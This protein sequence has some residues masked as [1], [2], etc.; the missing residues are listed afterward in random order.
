MQKY[1][2][3]FQNVLAYPTWT[4]IGQ[5]EAEDLLVAVFEAEDLQLLDDDGGHGRKV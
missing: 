4:G 2:F 1:V 5:V 3:Y